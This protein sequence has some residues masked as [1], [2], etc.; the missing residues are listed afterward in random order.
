MTIDAAG[1]SIGTRLNRRVHWSRVIH[2]ADNL[3]SSLVFGTPRM[4]PVY[5]RLLD[6]RK[7]KGGSAEMFW[8]GAFPGLS[9]EVDPRF[10]PDISEPGG[11]EIDKEEFKKQLDDYSSGL[12]RYLNTVGISVKSLAPQVADPDKHVKM[13]TEAVSMYLNI[14]HR[15]FM[16]SEE[17]R[18]A[19]SQDKLTWNTRLK[20]RLINFIEPSIIRNIVDR[21]IAIG[22]MRPPK[23]VKQDK[24]GGP[25]FDYTVDWPDINKPT[26]ED[27]ANLALKWTQATAQYVASGAIHLIPPEFYLT[28]VLGFDPD[29]VKKIMDA[30]DSAGGMDKLT[31]VDPS[32]TGGDMQQQNNVPKGERTGTAGSRETK[33]DSNQKKIEGAA[34]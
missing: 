4:Q 9:F 20:S 30:A 5:N 3:Q 26:D 8:K 10:V 17:G 24:D 12:S 25:T 2:V 7:I 29:I 34:S 22:V 16:G 14:P 32:Q 21:F 31:S 1:A 11:L 33:R 18:L 6:L 27:K 23:N 15:I 19:S 13:Q 28:D